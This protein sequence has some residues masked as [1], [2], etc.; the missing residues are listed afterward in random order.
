MKLQSSQATTSGSIARARAKMKATINQQIRNIDRL[1]GGKRISG[2][3][4]VIDRNGTIHLRLRYG[5]QP[6]KLADGSRKLK[7]ETL[8]DLID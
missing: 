3:E 1:R 6:L 2:E 8:D 7:A 4:L 5:T